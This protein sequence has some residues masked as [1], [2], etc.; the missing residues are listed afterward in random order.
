ML[1]R[2]FTKVLGSGSAG[3]GAGRGGGAGGNRIGG[4]AGGG[5][6]RGGGGAGGGGSQGGGGGGPDPFSSNVATLLRFNNLGTS[7]ISDDV[8]A[9]TWS[10]AGGVTQVAGIEGAA[11]LDLVGNTGTKYVSSTTAA[12]MANLGFGAGDFTIELTTRVTADPPTFFTALITTDAWSMR[13]RNLAAELEW[14]GLTFP[15]GVLKDGNPHRLMMA[16]AAG[17]LYAF[18]DGVLLGSGTQAQTLNTPTVIFVGTADAAGTNRF[19]G[20][21]DEV[22]I[23]KGVARATATYTPVPPTS[24]FP[25]ITAQGGGG[26][27]GALPNDIVDSVGNIVQSAYNTMALAYQ[28]DSA[29]IYRFGAPASNGDSPTLPTRNQIGQIDY[30]GGVAVLPFHLA[31]PESQVNNDYVSNHGIGICKVASGATVQNSSFMV[32]TYA[33]DRHCLLL[34]PTRRWQDFN[35][36][37][38]QV[39]TYISQGILSNSEAAD[40]PIFTY[41]T[42]GVSDTGA[43]RQGVMLTNGSATRGARMVAM[44]TETAQNRGSCTFKLGFTPTCVSIPSAGEFAFVPGWNHAEFKGEVAVV[45][46]GG[47]PAGIHW[48]DAHTG[49]WYDWWYEYTDMTHPGFKCQGNWTFMKVLGYVPLPTNMKAPT[50]CWANTGLVPTGFFDGAAGVT[51]VGARTSPLESSANRA[52]LL[53]VNDLGR[54]IPHGGCLI[55]GSKSEKTVCFIDLKPLYDYFNGMYL[56]SLAQNLETQYYQ[57][58]GS[59]APSAG[60]SVDG[61][62]YLNNTNGDVYKKSG[63]TWSI[64]GNIGANRGLGLAQN[65]WPYLFVDRPQ[66]TPIVAK[67][68][69]FDDGIAGIV[70]PCNY[71]YWD[72]DHT[73]RTPG[74]PG[75]P[76]ADPHKPR[77]WIVTK[78][79]TAYNWELGRYVPGSKPADQTP[80]PSEIVQVGTPITGLGTNITHVTAVR[81]YPVDLDGV[82]Y[83]PDDPLPGAL[84][85]MFAACNRAHRQIKIVQYGIGAADP[86]NGEVKFTLEDSRM[87]PVAFEFVDPYYRS[88]GVIAVCDF[89]GEVIRNYRILP[90]DYEGTHALLSANG[91]HITTTLAVGGKPFGFGTSNAP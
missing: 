6:G 48:Q 62:N 45:A 8:T 61:M 9:N 68:V 20:L 11:C 23:T 70:C 33:I 84:D 73:R 66:S 2:P 43:N 78:G 85:T 39:L 80:A 12:L 47:T 67:T 15:S 30:G 59:G 55:V 87:D 35:L 63:G 88:N 65:Q 19:D 89:T 4:G 57:L 64:I 21:I 49:P 42:P 53:D 32:A 1:L 44:G 69:T 81:Y 41:R 34:G 79:G 5:R 75:T 60:L 46:L 27:E 10:A 50:C 54:Y 17:V 18:V 36:R 91:E 72:K 58:T 24:S 82:V 29:L 90:I 16:R 13:F 25:A 37:S 26:G 3:G 51:N 22:R 77:A 71:G 86:T 52:R 28:S 38:A 40:L 76:L 83:D 74:A 14:N 56:D 31:G 7:T